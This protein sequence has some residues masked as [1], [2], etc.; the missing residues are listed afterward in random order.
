MQM[1]FNYISRVYSKT[2]ADTDSMCD[3]IAKADIKPLPRTTS[4][5]QRSLA[6]NRFNSVI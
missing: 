1:T 3:C 2:D 4:T 5:G 6:D